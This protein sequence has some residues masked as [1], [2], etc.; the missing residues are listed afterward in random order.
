MAGRADDDDSWRAWLDR[1]GPAIVLYA[2]QWTHSRADA[3]DAMQTAFLNFWQHRTT[4]ADPTA[5]LYACVRSAALNLARSRARRL[6]HER[7]GTDTAPDPLFLP[8]PDRNL[9]R[10][11]VE[12][13]IAQLPPDQREILVLKIWSDLTFAQIAEVL[14]INPNTAASRYRY[15]LNRLD[16]LLS[17]EVRP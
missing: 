7:P 5:Y 10:Q 17:Q 8:D 2:R 1:H 6:K 9:R 4:A 3:E 14:G 13:S 15:A 16:S 11:A 12:E